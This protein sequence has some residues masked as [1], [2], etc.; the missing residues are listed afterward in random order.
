MSWIGDSAD[1]G[2]YTQDTL[3]YPQTMRV[4]EGGAFY[5][6]LLKPNC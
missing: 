5:H 1:I 2:H 6:G 4:V 3:I